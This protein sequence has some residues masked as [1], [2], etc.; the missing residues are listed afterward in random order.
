MAGR[1]LEDPRFDT[2]LYT[3]PEAARF[4]GV[5]AAT[6]A[7]WV[8]RPSARADE[9]PLV[10]LIPAAPQYPTIPFVGLVEGM[11]VAVF[12]RAGVSMQ[13]IRKALPVVQ[14]EIGLKHALASHR[15]YTDGAAILYDFARH[16]DEDKMLAAVVTG[17]RVFTPIVSKYLQRITYAPDEWAERLVLPITD[18]PVV[19]VDPRRAFGRPVFVKGGARMEDVVDRFRAGE[20]LESVAGDFD[21]EAEDVEDVIRAA[22]PP[23]A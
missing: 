18:R 13:H 23:A 16:Q 12:R 14:K 15:L 3:V 8:D 1:K 21:L 11:V 9:R 22:L 19:E 4:L 17:Q 6:F 10:T 7:S 2:P 20:R 5:P